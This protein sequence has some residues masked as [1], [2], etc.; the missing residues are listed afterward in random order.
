MKN[1]IILS[2]VTFLILGALAGGT[3]LRSSQS[4]RQDL[5]PIEAIE[6][7]KKEAQN[8]K[9]KPSESQGEEEIE[10]NTIRTESNNLTSEYESSMSFEQQLNIA[11]QPALQEIL[12]GAG[13]YAANRETLSELMRPSTV[14]SAEDKA[15]HIDQAMQV[16]ADLRNEIA[17]IMAKMDETNN[18]AQSLI[19][20]AEEGDKEQRHAAWQKVKA[21]NFSNFIEFFTAQSQWVTTQINL[22]QLYKAHASNLIYDMMKNR[23]QS[24]DRNA[25][26][27]IAELRSLSAQL[28]SQKN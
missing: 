1:L 8:L 22:A 24:G 28:I 21:E 3:Y 20:A 26:E 7:A 4:L 17:L 25:D 23:I 6:A 16:A 27:A 10:V 19:A 9:N 11:I 14:T 13:Q 2:I 5:E 18:L 12:K 15:V